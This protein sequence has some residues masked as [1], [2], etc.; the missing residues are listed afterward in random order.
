MC[1]IVPRARGCGDGVAAAAAKRRALRV[2]AVA[3]AAGGGGGDA[4]RGGGGD[5]QAAGSRRDMHMHMLYVASHARPGGDW[6]ADTRGRARWGRGMH[7]SA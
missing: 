5:A 2:A 1:P 4:K 7:M 3:G 6:L